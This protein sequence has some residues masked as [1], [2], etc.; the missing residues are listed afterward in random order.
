M[1]AV[2]EGFCGKLLQGLLATEIRKLTQ[3]YRFR[4]DSDVTVNRVFMDAI[5]LGACVCTRFYQLAF[6]A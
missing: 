1:K 4:C 2:D 6:A 3:G 5:E